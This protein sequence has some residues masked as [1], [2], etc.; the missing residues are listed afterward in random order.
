M[1]FMRKWF[2]GIPRVRDKWSNTTRL[3]SLKFSD[4]LSILS[5]HHVGSCSVVF[6]DTFFS[7][8][9]FLTRKL[10]I[11]RI[12]FENRLRKY[13]E[14]KTTT[15]FKIEL[16]NLCMWP[17]AVIISWDSL[18][19]SERPDLTEN[20]SSS[21][22]SICTIRSDFDFP[23]LQRGWNPRKNSRVRKDFT[24]T[25]IML[26]IITNWWCLTSVKVF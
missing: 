9:S 21:E 26:I 5:R 14:N 2:Q 17:G 12:F 10:Y 13:L 18:Q 3:I 22:F 8:T 24:S 1:F 19:I 15:K 16:S 25:L 6:L 20:S 4:H 7:R 11:I 23:E